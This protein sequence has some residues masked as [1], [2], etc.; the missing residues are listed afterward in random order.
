MYQD[1]DYLRNN[2]TWHEEDS[3]WKAQQIAHVLS[4]NKVSPRSV[5]EVGCGAGGVLASLQ[6]RLET[7]VDFVGYEIS[8]QA[9]ERCVRRTRPRLR[10]LQEDLL[11]TEAT[12]VFDLVMAIDVFEHV[13]DCF[14]FLRQLRARAT[15]KVFHVPLDLSVQAVLRGTSLSEVRRSVGHLHYFTRDTALALLQDT[16]HQIV[17][18]RYTCGAIDLPSTNWRTRLMRAPRRAL[19]AL[20]DDLAARLLGGFSIVVLAR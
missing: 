14:G 11:A 3:P 16:G 10:F 6:E 18:V 8:P 4:R 2:P 20:N 9:Y 7:E 15:W 19:Y 13:E 17:D 1:G 5:C 12:T